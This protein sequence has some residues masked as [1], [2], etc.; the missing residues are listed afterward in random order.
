MGNLDYDIPTFLIG[1]RGKAFVEIRLDDY[2]AYFD[3]VLSVQ[4]KVRLL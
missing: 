1:N 3:E 4:E 2:S